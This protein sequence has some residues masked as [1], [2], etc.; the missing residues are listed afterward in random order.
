MNEYF[1]LL[2]EADQPK[3]NFSTRLGRPYKISRD[4]KLFCGLSDL[5]I[6]NAITTSLVTPS[7]D[8]P[9]NFAIHIPFLTDKFRLLS[10]PAGQY[11]PVTICSKLN[12]MMKES[13]GTLFTQDLCRFTFNKETGKTEIFINGKDADEQKRCTLIIFAGLNIPLGYS[14]SLTTGDLIFGSPTNLL[15]GRT[16]EHA[17]HAVASYSTPLRGDFDFIFVYLSIVETQVRVN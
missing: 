4:E 16:F 7:A 13:L 15:P 8:Y 17:T 6:P 12:K 11:N 1:Y 9:L 14:L 10:L 3:M 5:T 2:S